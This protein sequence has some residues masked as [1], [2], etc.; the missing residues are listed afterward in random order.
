MSHH[1]SITGQITPDQIPMIAENG[2]KPLLIIVLMVKSQ[3]SQPVQRLKQLLPTQ[4]SLIKKYL[5]LVVSLTNITSKNLRIS[6][7]RL[8]SQ[9]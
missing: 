8:S 3:A 4:A 7:I 5:L 6:L 2:L 1:I 9:C